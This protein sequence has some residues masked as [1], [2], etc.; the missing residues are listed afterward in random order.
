MLQRSSGSGTDLI[1][2]VFKKFGIPNVDCKL[3]IPK[4]Q[5]QNVK[6]FLTGRTNLVV[7]GANYYPICAHLMKLRYAGAFNPM[8]WIP[9]SS[10]NF[11][12]EN[13]KEEVRAIV[14]LFEEENSNKRYLVGNL[15][16]KSLVNS[17]QVLIGA[18]NGEELESAFPYDIDTIENQFDLWKLGE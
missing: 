5:S 2:S 1:E 11:Q 3:E 15:V 18:K 17:V 16:N 8:K 13:G 7:M 6:G 12:T 10:I 4:H 9:Q 14:S